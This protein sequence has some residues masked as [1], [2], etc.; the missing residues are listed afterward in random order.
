MTPS[1]RILLADDEVAHRELLA[2]ALA[3]CG[4]PLTIIPCETPEAFL[5]M[6]R[7]ERFDAVVL[8]YNFKPRRADELLLE[9]AEALDS[10]PV[11]VIS[12]SEQQ[13]VVIASLRAGVTDFIPKSEA[14]TGNLLWARVQQAIDKTHR[15]TS[16]RRQTKRRE[17]ELVKLAETDALT[18]LFNRRH[19]DRQLAARRFRHDR[20]Q[21]VAIVMLD[22]DHF[23]SVNDRLG[24]AAGD[25]VLRAVA[26]VL[27]ASCG[28]ADVPIRMGG[29]EFLV[30]RPSATPAE[31]WQWAERLRTA[32][33]GL[34]INVG[35]AGSV[36]VT[37]SLGI[38]HVRIGDLGEEAV[39][40]ADHALYLAKDRGRDRVCCWA[41][42]AA[43]RDADEAL[44][45]LPGEDD[46]SARRQLFARRAALWTSAC[47]H[48]LSC[49][50]GVQLGDL[51]AQ[52]AAGLGLTPAQQESSRRVGELAD[53]GKCVVPEELLS[54]PGGLVPSEWSII[55]GAADESLHIA[56][57]LG[58]A[59][60]LIEAVRCVPTR[61][62]TALVLEA[63]R[64]VGAATADPV[65]IESRIVAAA[66]TIISLTAPRP[67]R[68][69]RTL[70]EA[71]EELRR[72]RARQF[73]PDV[74]DAVVRLFATGDATPAPALAA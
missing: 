8:D 53:L 29:E 41:M 31:N 21:H 56:R 34:S 69:T 25:M 58:S 17:Q 37:V 60:A 64:G 62:D 72:G 67:Y 43:E 16:D 48:R 71:I 15:A 54:K 7:S 18:G 63:A 28:P 61:Y 74:V 49:D 55:H 46:A 1:L 27:R 20:R 23:K 70:P 40:R 44:L 12:S 4:Q 42:V 14:L 2:M 30:L 26:G 36:H 51:A 32:I 47:Q 10:C 9:A 22:L 73:D 3:S 59:P 13:D 19:L 6:V 11:V 33:A 24:H 65:P 39:A 66:A 45:D 35:A 38:E 57:A 50:S 68:P 52:I 5:A